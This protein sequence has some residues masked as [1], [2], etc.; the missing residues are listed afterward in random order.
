MY[1]WPTCVE[2]PWRPEGG[3]RPTDGCH[4]CVGAGNRTW[5]LWKSSLGLLS[6]EPSGAPESMS[7]GEVL[8]SS[9]KGGGF[10]AVSPS[11]DW[12]RVDLSLHKH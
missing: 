10:R 3:V 5:V 1:L 11:P 7:L 4:C 9:R 6:T 12:S 2:C 8:H